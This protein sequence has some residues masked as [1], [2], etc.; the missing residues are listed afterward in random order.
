MI[1]KNMIPKKRKNK[2][3]WCENCQ[4]K[5]STTLLFFEKYHT[6]SGRTSLINPLFIC[7]GCKP[8]FLDCNQFFENRP[9]LVSFEVLAKWDNRLMGLT[10]KKRWEFSCFRSPY[11]KKKLWR[12]KYI[13]Q[14][15]KRD[16]AERGT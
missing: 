4:S 11:F 1:W 13:W 10:S 7:D 5:E 3:L 9:R 12:I 2:D 6:E 15:G 8:L 14:N 16:E